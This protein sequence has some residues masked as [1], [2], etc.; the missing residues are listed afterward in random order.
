M[1]RSGPSLPCR[2]SRTE[3]EK[4]G[5][6]ESQTLRL[7]FYIHRTAD[8]SGVPA[9]LLQDAGVVSGL[10]VAAAGAAGFSSA[11]APTVRQ[12]GNE[13]VTAILILEAEG[14]HLAAH[15]FPQRELLLLD[16]LVPTGHDT[17][18]AVDVFIRKLGARTVASGRMERGA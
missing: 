13:G 2:C 7:A 12:R 4:T 11:A 8:F 17:D 9:A 18:K 16:V 1:I 15:T 6:R 10:L 5:R 14:C 3:D